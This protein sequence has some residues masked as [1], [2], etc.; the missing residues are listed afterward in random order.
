V[1]ALGKRPHVLYR[2][3]DAADRLLYIGITVGIRS[4]LMKHEVEKSWYGEIA[5]ISVEHFPNRLAVLAAEKAAI[6]AEK[7]LH[8]VQHNGSRPR[9][10][11]S[12]S[13]EGL[14]LT[15]VQPWTFRSR[16]SDYE[17]TVPLWLYWE[18]Y[19]DP[20]SDGYYI[21]EIEPEDLWR[22][23]MR[24]NPVSPA[25]EAIYGRGA[26]PI[27]WYIEGPGIA[28]GAPF[29]VV[30]HRWWVAAMQDGPHSWTARQ[31]IDYHREHSFTTYFTEPYDPETG[32]AVRWH[33]LP[34]IDKVWREH[35]LPKGPHTSK[36]GFIQ[37]ATGWKPSAFQPYVNVEL[38]AR[39]CG[40][41]R[42]SQFRDAWKGA[43]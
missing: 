35:D 42:P 26:V 34:V 43:A 9:P 32:D 3:F 23:W 20:I 36:G 39:D 27:G 14:D 12:R 41:A 31:A 6:Q 25:A 10:S 11:V 24:A 38:L 13:A 29:E 8:N 22:E 5:R 1:S 17:R 2:F 21:D 33:A 4:R 19:G 18:A 15:G 28:E 40:L 30:D 37:E 16:R 7:P